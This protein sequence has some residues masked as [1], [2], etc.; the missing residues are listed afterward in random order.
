MNFQNIPSGHNYILTEVEA[1]E[2]YIITKNTYTV[3][4][5]YDTLTVTVKDAEGNP[6]EWTASIENDTYYALPNTGGVGTSHLTFGG[7]LMIAAAMMYG[8]SQKRVR[9]K[10]GRR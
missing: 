10:E 8:Y 3:D 6:L 2:N 9:R 1:P 7:L 4:I 5:A